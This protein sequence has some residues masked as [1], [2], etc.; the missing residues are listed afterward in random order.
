MGELVATAGATLISGARTGVME[1]ASRGAKKAGG[2]VVGILPGAVKSESNPY[3]DVIIL[4]EMGHARNVI[5]A[6]SSDCLI[7]VAGGFGTLSEIA[8]ALKTGKPVVTLSSQWTIT[9]TIEAHAPEDAVKM[10]LSLC[11]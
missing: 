4:T 5:I 2:L 11:R 9:G 6:N 3:V 7:A 8:L 1:A 10:A